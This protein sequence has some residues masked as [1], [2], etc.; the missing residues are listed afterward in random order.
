MSLSPLVGGKSSGSPLGF[1]CHLPGS[2]SQLPRWPLVTPEGQVPSRNESPGSLLGLLWRHPGWVKVGTSV[3]AKCWRGL[4]CAFDF[5]DMV[6][7][8]PHFFF[9]LCYLPSGSDD[10][11]K[12]FCL[13]RLSYPWYF[14]WRGQAFLG[15]LVCYITRCCLLQHAVWDIGGKKKAGSA[16]LGC[17]LGANAHSRSSLFNSPLSSLLRLVLCVMCRGFHCA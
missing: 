16:P 9:F 12:V 5:A 4:G 2:S 17:S 8:W 13:P 10:F 3:T 1:R 7:V 15:T 6:G 14:C 11:L